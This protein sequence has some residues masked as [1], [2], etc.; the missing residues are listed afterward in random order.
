M[1]V[2]RRI[3]EYSALTS[4][5]GRENHGVHRLEKLDLCTGAS[6]QA[7]V[8]TAARTRKQPQRENRS[9]GNATSLF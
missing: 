3:C 1:R 9:P 2:L 6:V 4:A 8:Q 7:S 5:L